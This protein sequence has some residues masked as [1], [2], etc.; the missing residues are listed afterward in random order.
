MLFFGCVG[1][2]EQQKPDLRQILS[3]PHFRNPLD[4]KIEQSWKRRDVTLERVSFQGRYGTRI[5]ALIAYSDLARARPLPVLLC[6]PGSPNV[7]EDLLERVDVLYSWADQGFFTISI[8]RPYHGDREGDLSQALQEKGL[9]KVWGE[10][11]YDLM[12][13]LDYVETRPEADAERIGMLGLS[14]GGVEALLL[15]ALDERI[16]VFVSV[17]GHLAW[18]DIFYS[19]A[20]KH[21]FRGLELR[22]ELVRQGA[23]GDEVQ[24]AFFA[25]YPG[26]EEV[27]ALALAS[28]L[29]PRPLLLMVGAEDPFV[30]AAATRHTHASA[31]D[32]YAQS[33]ASEHLALLEVEGVGHSF[34][35]HMQ[36]EALA[37]FI[38]WLI[39]FP[40]AA[41]AN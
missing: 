24:R 30:P 11:I 31:E 16:N 34:N 4:S 10:S 15:G 25:A 18:G 1:Q 6:M 14:M 35:R 20:W 28:R 41:G 33:G 27:D 13:A 39:D 21:I 3:V 5:P 17:D 7:K 2:Q 37:W 38:R 40:V 29:A 9:L 22:H 19:D 23:H 32:A 26:L 8:D 12:R 36:E